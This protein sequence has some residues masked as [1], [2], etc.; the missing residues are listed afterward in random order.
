MCLQ[1]N[2]FI[3]INHVANHNILSKLN[4]D[5][6]VCSDSMIGPEAPDL[7][8][9]TVCKGHQATP[10]GLY[11]RQPLHTVYILLIISSLAAVLLPQQATPGFLPTGDQHNSLQWVY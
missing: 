10:N 4:D 6:S 3:F 11:L 8:S 1:E 2:R 9:L 7:A 5:F